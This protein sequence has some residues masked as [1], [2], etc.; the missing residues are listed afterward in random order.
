MDA[1]NN[2]TDFMREHSQVE[3][4]PTE[5]LDLTV[6]SDADTFIELH[7]YTR[8]DA[9]IHI[10]LMPFILTVGLF[11]NLTILVAVAKIQWM[12]TITNFYLVNLAMADITFL[13]VAIGEKL[14]QYSS[15]PFIYDDYPKGATGCILIPFIKDFCFFSSIFLVT[16]ISMERFNAACRPLKQRRDSGTKLRYRTAKLTIAAWVTSLAVSSLRISASYQFQIYCLI[17]PDSYEE[18]PEIIGECRPPKEWISYATKCV[19]IVIFV[20]AMGI[21]FLFYGKITR[22]VNCSTARPNARSIPSGASV[23]EVRITRMVVATGVIFFLCLAPFELFS[24]LLMILTPTNGNFVSAMQVFRMMMYLNSAINPL[25]YNVA[26]PRY[27]KAFRLL[28]SCKG[29]ETACMPGRCH[30]SV[31]T[32]EK[33][34]SEKL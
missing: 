7:A 1:F 16:C 21:N 26:N 20:L 12:R 18:Y 22:A 9:V 2:T 3:C 32:S 17:W 28:F 27:R 30:Q 6:G 31:T 4:L 8:S 5:T 15:T 24:A 10:V 25:I 13:V 11:G 33:K 19:Q 23:I 34:T 29:V 14:H